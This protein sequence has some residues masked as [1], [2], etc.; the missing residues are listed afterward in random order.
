MLFAALAEIVAPVLPVPASVVGHAAPP[1]PLETAGGWFQAVSALIFVILIFL[2]F[3]AV[4]Q[5]LQRKGLFGA[6][7][8]T[9]PAMKLGVVQTIGLDTKSRL[10][11]VRRG[12]TGHLLCLHPQGV[13]LV[14]SGIALEEEIVPAETSPLEK[15]GTPKHPAR[16][17]HIILKEPLR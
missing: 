4:L 10:V 11:L 5:R 2:V 9:D 1:L 14:E 13:T 8:S 7:P 3:A 6:S 16:P 17:R 15:L 12:N